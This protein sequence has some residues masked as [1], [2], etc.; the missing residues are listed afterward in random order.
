MDGDLADLPKLVSLKRC[1]PNV[2]L[3]VDEAHSLGVRGKAGLGIAEESNTIQ[4]IDVLV[5]TL[6][7]AIGG[8][9]AYIAASAKLVSY[10][11]NFSR[12]FI[13]STMLSPVVVA[14]DRFVFNRL[15]KFEP[16]RKKLKKP[17]RTTQKCPHNERISIGGSKPHNTSTLSR[18]S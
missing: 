16:E 10:M 8:M 3:Y 5:G 9:G 6:G 13:F 12:P 17:K 15:E 18:E 2:L 11:I 7:K 14:W 1:Y 4:D